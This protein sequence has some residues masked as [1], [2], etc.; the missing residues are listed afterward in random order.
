MFDAEI[1]ELNFPCP[2]IESLRH[3]HLEQVQKIFTIS[4]LEKA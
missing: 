4:F 2:F 1:V 3:P